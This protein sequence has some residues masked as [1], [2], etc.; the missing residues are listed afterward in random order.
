MR[1]NEN[2]LK[3]SS[4]GVAGEMSK[5]G[6]SYSTI[7]FNYLTKHFLQYVTT[8]KSEDLTL[9]LYDGHRSHIVLILTEWARQH[10]TIL[11][12]EPTPRCRYILAV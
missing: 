7:F 4:T 12:F 10:N 6:C 9:I 5:M 8:H 11:S 3:G 2:F 1:W